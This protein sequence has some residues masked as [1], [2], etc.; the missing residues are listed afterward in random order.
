MKD[1]MKYKNYHGSFHFDDKE[2]IFYGKIEFI[3]AVVTYE[4]TDAKGLRKAFEDAV[5]DYLA[6]CK[7]QKITPETPFKGSFNVRLGQELHRRVAVNAAHRH[8]SINKFVV[9]VLEKATH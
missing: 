5:N 9:E 7:K 4:A 8:M 3:N 6:C 2:F 1:L